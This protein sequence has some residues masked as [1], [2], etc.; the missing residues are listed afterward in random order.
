LLNVL[1][2]SSTEVLLHFFSLDLPQDAGLCFDLSCQTHILGPSYL[3]A[4]YDTYIIYP[5]YI[6]IT[7]IQSVTIRWQVM[8]K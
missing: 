5:Y 4:G 2:A 8:G 6:H 7:Y 3:F 1:N